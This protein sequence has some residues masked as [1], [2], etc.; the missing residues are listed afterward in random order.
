ML[1]VTLGYS[2]LLGAFAQLASIF[3]K[4]PNGTRTDGPEPMINRNAGTGNIP[5]ILLT[6]TAPLRTRTAV[7]QNHC[8]PFIGLTWGPKSSFFDKKASKDVLRTVLDVV[9]P[10]DFNS[11]NEAS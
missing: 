1:W 7:N 5:E 3:M 4:L 6:G 8:E 10:Q 11:G 9:F 2:A